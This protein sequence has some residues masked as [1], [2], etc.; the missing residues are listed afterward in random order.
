MSLPL[1]NL[2]KPSILCHRPHFVP[3]LVARQIRYASSRDRVKAKKKS[4]WTL[5]QLKKDVGNLGTRGSLHLPYWLIIGDVVT[6][7]AARMRT[8]LVRNDKAQYIRPG[9]NTFLLPGVQRPF[10]KKLSNNM[11]EKVMLN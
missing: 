4:P 7:K 9:S 3:F 6:V 11:Y 2:S 10:V 1:R 5:V 8:D